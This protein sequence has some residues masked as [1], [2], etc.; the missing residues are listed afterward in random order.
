MVGT[1]YHETFHRCHPS[2]VRWLANTQPSWV[3]AINGH[4]HNTLNFACQPKKYSTRLGF[5]IQLFGGAGLEILEYV[6]TMKLGYSLW[7]ITAIPCPPL[8]YLCLSIKTP[9][10]VRQNL[11]SIIHQLNYCLV[12]PALTHYSDIASDIPSGSFVAY[13]YKFIFW[14]SVWHSFWHSLLTSSLS[15]ELAIWGSA[16]SWRRSRRE[17]EARRRGW[18]VAPLLKSRGPH[19]AGGEK[20][21]YYF[22]WSSPWPSWQWYILS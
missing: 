6:G 2:P 9:W 17:E 11:R 12:I 16:T 15:P 19:L 3:D 4:S 5:L 1:L 20:Q 10:H 8:L 14:H 21:N 18:E 22:E 7:I 13:I